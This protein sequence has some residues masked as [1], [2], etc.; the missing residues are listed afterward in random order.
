[1]KVEEMEVVCPTCGTKN[2]EYMHTFNRSLAR[3][4]GRLY[5][6]VKG[7]GKTVDIAHTKT[8]YCNVTRL[9]FW[10]LIRSYKN[11]ESDRKAGLWE[12]T[13][14]GIAFVEGTKAVYSKVTTRR[15]KVV[16][17][18][19]DAIMFNDVSEGY[20]YRKDY[21]DQAREQIQLRLT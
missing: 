19:G 9:Q 5:S 17:Y 12:I 2:I 20:Q 10:K 18:Q 8:E 7:I 6:R 11:E 3:C 1:M 13:E 4:L 21:R 14:E 15:S 16:S